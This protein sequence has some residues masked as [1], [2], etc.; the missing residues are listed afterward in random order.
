[1]NP[2]GQRQKPHGHLYG[3]PR[4]HLPRSLSSIDEHSTT[5]ERCAR[6][7]VTDV[8]T[9]KNYD[10]IDYS[11]NIESFL[12]ESAISTSSTSQSTDGREQGQSVIE[13]VL[14]G[15]TAAVNAVLRFVSNLF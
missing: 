15:L 8:G 1:M 10:Q 7:F 4:L 6:R 12:C 3:V 9:R 13:Q 11:S 2:L 5:G 14:S